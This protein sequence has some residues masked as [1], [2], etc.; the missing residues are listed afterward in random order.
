MS[1]VCKRGRHHKL[2]RGRP[3]SSGE[4]A[5]GLEVWLQEDR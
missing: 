3:V 4:D 2:W 1:K 5:G